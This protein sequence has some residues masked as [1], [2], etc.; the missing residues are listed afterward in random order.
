MDPADPLR[1]D[2]DAASGPRA[3]ARSC[4]SPPAA[5]F[6]AGLV[7]AA[8]KFRGAFERSRPG[9]RRSRRAP[10]RRESVHSRAGRQSNTG[11]ED[12]CRRQFCFDPASSRN[13]ARALGGARRRS[14]G[15]DPGEAGRG[16]RNRPGA[17]SR[18]PDRRKGG[19][20]GRGCGGR[21]GAGAFRRALPGECAM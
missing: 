3:A 20:G 13:R 9:G 15:G 16:R 5:E 10:W 11:N 8:P 19:V 4:V 1:S 2:F 14:N 17:R 12:S 21:A 7:L 6:R 18:E